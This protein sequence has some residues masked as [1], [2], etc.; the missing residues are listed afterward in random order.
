MHHKCMTSCSGMEGNV[1]FK[2][3]ILKGARCNSKDKL[4]NDGIL[5]IGQ[6]RCLA[7]CT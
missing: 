5:G 3:G 7:E 1:A 4:F 6:G 2:R